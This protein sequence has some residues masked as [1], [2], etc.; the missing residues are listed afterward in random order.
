MVTE[1]LQKV[2]M[3]KKKLYGKTWLFNRYNS[4]FGKMNKM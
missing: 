3:V 2:N 4:V 1:W